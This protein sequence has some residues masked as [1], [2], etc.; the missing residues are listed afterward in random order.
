MIYFTA[1]TSNVC[2]TVEG[3]CL[4]YL[5][6]ITLTVVWLHKKC[7]I[8]RPRLLKILTSKNRGFFLDHPLRQFPIESEKIL[9]CRLCLFVSFCMLL[10]NHKISVRL[11]WFFFL[12]TKFPIRKLHK[13]HIG[14]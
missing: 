9:C 13:A 12:N 1:H 11:I 14:V 2:A 5:V 6:C 7:Y 10:T 3:R 4:E 8:I